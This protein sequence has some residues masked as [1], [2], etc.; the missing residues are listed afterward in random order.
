MQIPIL[1]IVM[2]AI[3]TGKSTLA[4][5]LA[6]K[7]HIEILSADDIEVL[8]KDMEDGDIEC[9][10]MASFF[11]FLDQKQSFILDGLNLSLTSRKLYIN[12]AI[13]NGYKIHIYDLGPGNKNSLLR[14]LK[15]PR[16][17]PQE[18]WI[19]NAKRNKEIYEKPSTIKEYIDKLYTLY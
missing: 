17:I 1:H 11:Y 8:N 5:I 10:I 13:N 9:E 15:E 2:G 14:R 6:D 16:G 4:K 19:E 7:Y 12:K 18:R 3:G